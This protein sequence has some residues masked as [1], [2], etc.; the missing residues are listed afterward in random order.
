V[1]VKV[2][3]GPPLARDIADGIGVLDA[4]LADARC[5]PRRTPVQQPAKLG[6]RGVQRL[7][8]CS[9]FLALADSAQLMEA[10]RVRVDST[11]L[12]RRAWDEE[13][14][15]ALHRRRTAQPCTA[16]LDLDHF[17]RYNDT[18]DHQAG[19]APPW[20]PRGRFYAKAGRRF[21]ARHGGEE[22]R[23]AAPRRRMFCRERPHARRSR[24]RP[25]RGYCGK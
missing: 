10:R 21:I 8:R 13:L 9:T 1:S 14:V 19:D 4:K 11:S 16:L 12:N 15:K 23:F 25:L 22:S 6:A 17:K 2:L 18:H 24:A 5:S 3:E 7:S 20:K